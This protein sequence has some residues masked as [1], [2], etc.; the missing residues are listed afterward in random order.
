M[1]RRARKVNRDAC[2]ICVRWI[3]FVYG[4]GWNAKSTLDGRKPLP[5]RTCNACGSANGG[6]QPVTHYR[7]DVHEEHVI[8]ARTEERIYPVDQERVN[9]VAALVEMIKPLL[10]T[11]QDMVHRNLRTAPGSL[12][13]NAVVNRGNET[14]LKIDSTIREWASKHQDKPSG[15]EPGL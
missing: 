4:C 1:I 11:Y 15:G 7:I 13:N 6:Y 10:Q 12:E 3:C 14:L 5:E 8:Q 2:P 9:D